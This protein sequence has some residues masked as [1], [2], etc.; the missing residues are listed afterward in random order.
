MSGSVPLVLVQFDEA[1]AGPNGKLYAARTCGRVMDDGTGRW[2][3]WLEFIPAGGGESDAVRTGQETTQPNVTDLR[4]WA[5][6]LTR[7]YLEG[8]LHRALRPPFAPTAERTLD[9]SPAYEGPAT[10]RS[11]A[12]TSNR[13]GVSPR[14]VLNP[15]AVYAQGESV[16][17]QE[18][19]ALDLGHLRS[20]VEAYDLAP[21]VDARALSERELVELITRRVR[22][23]L[24][25]GENERGLQAGG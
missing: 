12:R 11:A 6:G 20:I 16:L 18:L 19:S 2:E 21:L 8:A 7:A 10:H 14:P 22:G 3:G 23:E 1:I 13:H 25:E 15:F 4:Y 17:R 5:T 24:R 9:A